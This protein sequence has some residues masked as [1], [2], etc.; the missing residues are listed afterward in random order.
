MALTRTLRLGLA[1]LGLDLDRWDVPLD[2][3]AALLDTLFIGSFAV[4]PT[5]FPSTSLR[6]NVRG[7]SYVGAD[8]LIHATADTLA[9][10]VSSGTSLYVY[11]MA[12]GTIGTGAGW[13][14]AGAGRYHPLAIVV[15]GVSAVSSIVDCRYPLPLIGS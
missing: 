9:M 11:L 10:T 12:N 14:A 13:P 2:A 7:G 8:G 6:F 3:N 15:G 1:M 4:V 5:E